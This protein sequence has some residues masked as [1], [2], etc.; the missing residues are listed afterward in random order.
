GREP[1]LRF[2]H[3]QKLQY[4]LCLP[5]IV[6]LVCLRHNISPRSCQHVL[7]GGAAHVESAHHAF[8]R[9]QGRCRRR[10]VEFARGLLNLL[11]LN[12]SVGHRNVSFLAFVPRPALARGPAPDAAH[13]WRKCPSI[14]YAALCMWLAAVRDG[15]S[16]TR[17]SPRP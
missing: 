3:G 14:L 13:S 11:N 12:K 4:F 5:R 8:A 17:E 6:A 15:A 2:E 1:M 10:H 16:H 9:E 7:A